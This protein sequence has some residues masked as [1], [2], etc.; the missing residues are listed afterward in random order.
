MSN[1]NWN[2]HPVVSPQGSSPVKASAFSWDD[3]P[4]VAA[5]ES[6]PGILENVGRGALNMVGTVGRAVDRFTGAPVRSAIGA[7][8]D[9]G[10]PAQAYLS[11]F[12]ENP[13]NAPTGKEIA[14][15]VGVSN[16]ALSD[17]IPSLYSK[18][19]SGLSLKKGG[20]LDPTASGVAGFGV[21]IAADPLNLIGV[22]E[23]AD[24]GKAGVKAIAGSAARGIG[25]S[26][27]AADVISG[28]NLATKGVEA[29][30]TAANTTGRVA[31]AAKNS[32]NQLLK[33]SLAE[34]AKAMD[35]IA[36]KNGI[37]RDLMSP[38]HE[39]GD[40]SSITRLQKNIAEGALGQKYLENHNA[41]L[42][43][44]TEALEKNISGKFGA[45]PATAAD[46]GQVLKDA[47]DGHVSN[48]F[49]DAD[50]TYSSAAK[51][52]PGLTINK[53]AMN[54]LQSKAIGMKREAMRLARTSADPVQL[55]QANNL[56]KWADIIL[57]SKGT[58][59]EMS[60]IVQNVGKAAYA[61]TPLGQIPSDMKKLRELYDTGSE[62]LIHSIRKVDQNAADRL[63]VN[64]AEIKEML[65]DKS[66]LGKVVQDAKNP[67]AIFNS[68]V[69]RGG[70]AQIETLKK[71]LPTETFNAM[72]SKY[73][74]DLVKYHPDGLVVNFGATTKS[75]EKNAERLSYLFKP[76]ELA[77]TAELLKFGQRY[78]SPVL[79]QLATGASAGFKGFVKNLQ[80]AAVDEQALD[81]MKNKARGLPSSGGVAAQSGANVLPMQPSGLL[82]ERSGI[83]RR[84]KLS[85]SVSP[86]TYQ[87]PVMP[88]K[89]GVIE[90]PPSDKK[91]P[92]AKG[93]TKWANDGIEKLK[94]HDDSVN[95]DGLKD[96][97]LADPQGKKLLIAASD[98]KPGSKA[99]NRIMERIKQDYGSSSSKR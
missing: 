6:Q 35:S 78:G 83:E 97:L 57:Q 32:I 14:Q 79:S 87:R 26:A 81:F 17:V 39:F 73:L 44:T 24:I 75:L 31:E 60:E 66:M 88:G 49:N 4:V 85:Q 16:A 48:V 64:N 5:S 30:K 43:K 82:R 37:P 12:G 29:A 34:D 68:L 42:A 2:D 45:P 94:E 1:F 41:G 72:R 50:I 25:Y 63:I 18:D 71:I 38:A 52:F 65:G 27:K 74:T 3:H 80:G 89:A 69:N 23:V 56:E 36:A 28:T 62:S 76:E 77:D 10:N 47:V 67:E 98:L 9:G 22:G 90:P 95:I 13:D 61:K 96:K 11:Q 15:K 93:P 70:S 51:Q 19:G 40:A 7:L 20:L 33:P 58:Y 91:E 46:A 92:P 59:K 53:D 8:Q 54:A 99:M 21:D 84:L 86:S 55:S